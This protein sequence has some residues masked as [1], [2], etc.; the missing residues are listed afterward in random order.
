MTI[1]KKIQLITQNTEEIIGLDE[2]EKLIESGERLKHYIGFEI[3][4]RI[5]LGTGLI[6]L[7]KVKDFIEAGVD[8]RIFLADWHAWLNDKLN[9]DLETIKKVA[10][11]YYQEGFKAVYQCLGGNPADL[12]FVLGSDLYHHNDKYW[13]T[14]I[15]ISKNLTLSR[16]V[17][18]TTIMGREA[19]ENVCFAWLIYPP[20]QVADVFIQ[21]LNFVHAGMDQ[22]K[23]H[24]IAREVA[25]KLKISPLKD[26]Q[27]KIVKPVA[28]HHPLILG[29][30]KPPKWPVDKENL[31]EVWSAMKMSKSKPDSAVFI[32]DS[33]DEIR[34]KINKAFCPEGEI[35]FNPILDWAKNIIFVNESRGIKIKREKKYGGDVS[36]ESY[37]K[38]AQDFKDKKLYPTDLKNFVAEWLVEFLKPVREHFSQGRAKEM[39]E[40]LEKIISLK[41]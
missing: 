36:Y 24:V 8:C 39:K 27:W 15:D 25:T 10:V 19:G 28:V 29:L 21:N 9:G 30:N 33:E 23:A 3:S 31:R 41:T 7:Q 11:G 4:G 35:E 38:L 22:R 5:H 2:L 1:K 14:V 18:S 17:K 32:D 13:Q 20:M 12:K 6:C 40:E 37:E 34:R 16:V 26:K